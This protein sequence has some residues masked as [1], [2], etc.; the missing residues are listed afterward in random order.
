M[1]GNLKQN[2]MQLSR[3]EQ[4]RLFQM[5]TDNADILAKLIPNLPLV[6][7]ILTGHSPVGNNPVIQAYEVWKNN[8]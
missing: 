5:L 8:R 7:Y 1:T 6:D 2:V 3:E 4:H